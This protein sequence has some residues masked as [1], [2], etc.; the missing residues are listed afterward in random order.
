MLFLKFD[1]LD[2][3]LNKHQFTQDGLFALVVLCSVQVL[4]TLR[5]GD[6]HLVS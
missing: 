1:N 4:L 5:F 3:Y 2:L 6:T